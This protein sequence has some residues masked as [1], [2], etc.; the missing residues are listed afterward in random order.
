MRTWWNERRDIISKEFLV[1][2]VFSSLLTQNNIVLTKGNSRHLIP[3]TM[4]TKSYLVTR[5]TDGH[6]TYI[7]TCLLN[8]CILR[9]STA[10]RKLIWS[11]F[12][13][14]LRCL[15]I[16]SLVSVLSN[17]PSTRQV[18]STSVRWASPQSWAHSN[19]T[20][21]CSIFPAWGYWQLQDGWRRININI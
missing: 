5:Y 3:H 17:R 7:R 19:A 6:L 12:F 10:D 13:V 20:Q 8:S 16:S 4:A 21:L 15:R 18:V 1:L 9:S 11:V 2:T 14:I